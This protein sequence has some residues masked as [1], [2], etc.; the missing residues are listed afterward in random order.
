VRAVQD[1]FRQA[2]VSPGD[3]AL[4]EA[5]EKLTRT[6][7]AMTR[8]DVDRLRGHGFDDEAIHD[9]FQVAAYF[10]YIN[11]VCDGL[12]IDREDFM[13]PEPPGWKRRGN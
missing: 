10:N 7:W 8:E 1:D 3:R 2:R 5:C 13:P 12:G 9:A 4:L 11:R 6:P